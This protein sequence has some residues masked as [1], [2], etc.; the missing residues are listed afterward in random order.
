M[1]ALRRRVTCRKQVGRSRTRPF[2]DGTQHCPDNRN[3]TQNPAACIRGP[4]NL[5]LRAPLDPPLRLTVPA[6][7]FIDAAL[8]ADASLDLPEGAVRHAQ[9]L[10]LQ[11]G[12]PVVLFNGK[13]GEWSAVVAAMGR[14]TVRVHI[15]AFCDVTREL[16]VHVTLAVGMPANER[17]DTLVEKATELGVAVIQ[18]LL[19]ARAVLRLGGERALR[20][21]AHWQ[22]VAAAASEQSG[23]T[24]VPRVEPVRALDE[25]ISG[26]QGGASPL[27]PSCA[28]ASPAISN[29]ATPQRVLLSPD[30]RA[31]F[32]PI[33]A[34]AAAGEGLA[35]PLVCLSGPEGGLTDVEQACAQRWGFVPMS[36]GPRILRADTAPLALLAH[37]ALGSAAPARGTE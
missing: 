3:S 25:W 9:V 6:R 28:A 10:R 27:G 37:V 33:S 18:P 19:C 12:V 15:V 14:S 29:P 30:A 21:V 11:P 22:A 16:A 7:F 26:L 5:T 31:P 23:R 1:Q 2:C 13:G 36:L 24:S 34:L 8:S 20:K 4:R 17:M 35:R 32:V